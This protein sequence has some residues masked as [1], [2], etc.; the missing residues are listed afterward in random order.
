MKHILVSAC[1]LGVSCRYDG[2]SKPISEVIALKDK[3]NI[4]P[5]CAE[6]MG[7][8]STPRV[9]CEIING[10]VINRD[11]E[12]KTEEYRRGAEEVLRLARLFDCDTAVL[13]ARSPSCGCGE[14]YD[15]SFTEALTEGD[16]ITA[17]LLKANGIKVLNE[18]QITE[19]QAVDL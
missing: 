17:S 1:L 4:I 6:V 2:K 12:D 19:L 8:L 5:V 7:G 15:G 18:E 11:G 14:V 16:G 3:Y 10:R 13:K 9:P